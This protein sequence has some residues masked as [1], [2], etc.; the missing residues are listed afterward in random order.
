[1]D[2]IFD[3]DIG[4][5]VVVG[6]DQHYFHGDRFYRRIG[7]GWVASARIGG[8]WLG[9]ELRALPAGL[10]VQPAKKRGRHG[11]GPP[12]QHGKGRGPKW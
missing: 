7:S 8:P 6:Y 3:S 5:Y 10:A 12:A 9:V 11:G 4:V 1:V 2:L